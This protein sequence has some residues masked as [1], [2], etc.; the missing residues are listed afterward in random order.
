MRASSR[1]RWR[2]STR[3]WCCDVYTNALTIGAD[4]EMRGATYTPAGEMRAPTIEDMLSGLWNILPSTALMKRATFDAI[5]GV[6]E[7]FAPESAMGRQL[8][9]AGRARTRPLRLPRRADVLY[10]VAGSVEESLKRRRVWKDDSGNPDT[11]RVERYVRNSELMQRLVRERF[12]ERAT[13]LLAAIRRATAGVLVSVGLTAM[14][15]YDRVFARRCYRLAL[16]YDRF[17]AK[18]YLR[19]AWTWL[20]ERLARTIQ[21]PCRRDFSARSRVRPMRRKTAT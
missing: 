11:M 7:E 10:R 5:G 15:D 20:P 4:G 14:L 12:G 21:R 8:L 18:T 19:L 9:H 16:H 13:R 3:H 2:R 6:R 17:N 1:K